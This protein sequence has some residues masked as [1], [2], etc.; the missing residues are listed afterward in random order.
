M[1]VLDSTG[2]AAYNA[3]TDIPDSTESLMER[4]R[5][6][7]HGLYCR[8]LLSG[9]PNACPFTQLGTFTTTHYFWSLVYWSLEGEPDGM[10][11]DPN[12]IPC[13]TLC[14]PEVVAQVL[15]GGF[16]SA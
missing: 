11:A 15:D 3:A 1:Y 16:I 2:R 12:G 14:A 7:P 5:A 6:A 13:E 10:D 4:Y 9:D 8:D